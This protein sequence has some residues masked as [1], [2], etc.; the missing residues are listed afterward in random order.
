M[1]YKKSRYLSEATFVCR[2][3]RLLW[4]QPRCNCCNNFRRQRAR[5]LRSRQVLVQARCRAYS[6][7]CYCNNTLASAR[8]L[9]RMRLPPLYQARQKLTL[10]TSKAWRRSRPWAIPPVSMVGV[11]LYFIFYFRP[12]FLCFTFANLCYLHESIFAFILLFI[13]STLLPIYIIF[14][15]FLWLSLTKFLKQVTNKNDERNWVR[16]AEE[17]LIHIDQINSLNLS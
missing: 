14:I 16:V 12:L 17:L 11:H 7:N 2:T 15:I 6:I 9:L 5:R 3:T 1:T 13:L 8:R 10:R 4:R